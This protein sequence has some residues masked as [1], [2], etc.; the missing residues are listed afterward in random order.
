MTWFHILY[1]VAIVI[2]AVFLVWRSSRGTL[3]GKDRVGAFALLGLAALG[4]LAN[5]F[6][7]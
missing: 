3:Q 4:W 6:G 2:F 5:T 1:G 7:W